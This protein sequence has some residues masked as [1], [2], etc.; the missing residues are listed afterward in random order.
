MRKQMK[1]VLR[2]YKHVMMLAG[3]I[4]VLTYTQQNF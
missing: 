4:I 1:F 3:F 2:N